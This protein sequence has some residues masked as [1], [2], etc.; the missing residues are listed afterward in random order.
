MRVRGPF[1]VRGFLSVFCALSLLQ[2]FGW[3]AIPLQDASKIELALARG[4]SENPSAVFPLTIPGTPIACWWDDETLQVGD[5]SFL[6]KD[7]GVVPKDGAVVT[8]DVVAENGKTL[9]LVIELREDGASYKVNDFGVLGNQLIDKNLEI[10]A[11][12]DGSARYFFNA[13]GARSP[14][15]IRE[16]RKPVKAG[17]PESFNIHGEAVDSGNLI[18][19]LFDAD[20]KVMFMAFYPFHDPA[21]KFAFV[22][23]FTDREKEILQMHV[24]QWLDHEPPRA[25]KLRFHDLYTN[26]DT[27][28]TVTTK[29]E[30]KTGR[31][32]VPFDVKG[33][34]GG[35]FKVW[36][37]L[38][39]ENGKVL[40]S[41]YAFYAK[42]I[43]GKYPWSNTQYG[44]EDSVPPPWTRPVFEPEGF[45]CWN[46]EVKF[47]DGEFIRSIV[48]ANQ[49]LLAKPVTILW[50]D[51]PLDFTV[52]L[53]KANVSFADYRFTAVNAPVSI[54]AR[55]EFDGLIWCKLNYRT[56][57][58]SLRLVVPVRRD[59]VV[60]FDDCSD[61]MKKLALPAGKTADFGY[62]PSAKAWWWMGS[63]V[64][65]LMG[66]NDNLHGWHCKNLSD[67]FHLTVNDVEAAFTM[68]FVDVP[69]TDAQERSLEFYLQPT[70]VKSKDVE[71]S[72]TPR[73][74]LCTWTGTLGKFF[75]V[76][77]PGQINDELVAKF[78]KIQD[79]GKRVFF[80]SGARVN[81][82]VQPWWSWWGDDWYEHS[83]PCFFAEEVRFKNRAD[84]D[85]GVWVTGCLNSRSFFEHKLHSICW[86]LWH[87]PFDDLYMDL[88]GPGRCWNRNHG[89]TWTDD[90]GRV[91]HDRA[92][93]TMRELL[94]RIYREMKKKNPKAN[95]IGHLQFQRTPSDVF[96][97][98]LYMGET[99]DRFIRATMS[100]YDVLNPEMMQ[101]QYASRS[102]EI[103]INMI[104]QIDRA[105]SMYS[106]HLRK[107]YD[108]HTPENDR[109]N[110]HA[111][112]YFKIHDLEISPQ[113][114]GANQWNDP[115]VILRGLGAARTHTAYYKQ[116]DPVSVSNPDPRLIWAMYEGNGQKFLIILNDTDRE[117]KETVTVRGLSAVGTD[118]F[119]RL[120]YHFETGSCAITLPPRESLF[121]HFK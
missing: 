6:F 121:I 63:A 93:K 51:E 61:P 4:T 101:I 5:K 106:P 119:N 88:A 107:T 55:V 24:D 29:L 43:D 111:T 95:I 117:L 19:N 13:V 8:V 98:Q 47:D 112:A 103:S 94:K 86:F 44:A 39:D 74:K 68:N 2:L 21:T 91:Q 18:F 79:S 102:T 46:R 75:D 32:V 31:A 50:N 27:G 22:A 58:D 48:S 49:E 30:P 28:Y 73:T 85:H 23:I 36:F 100:Y 87:S 3:S 7:L 9:K 76:K 20:G 54:E 108:A 83:D 89:C 16:Q 109:I 60:G 57:V 38:L 11:K 41:D 120:N 114:L 99:Y 105:M 17:K 80:Y 115:D 64:S 37:D 78:K 62:D 72:L 33:L 82:P 104:P 35:Y 26:E 96:F 84:R 70:P 52:T 67:G 10:T 118:I 56:P 34:R 69:I 92:L 53:I 110:R 14:R 45:H 81:S 40:Q 77:L 42:P 12:K 97:D 65:G 113:G 59:R 116:N 15:F 1:S 25:L 66:G 71:F 90:F